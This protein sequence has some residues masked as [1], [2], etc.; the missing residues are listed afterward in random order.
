MSSSRNLKDPT[1]FEN[2]LKRRRVENFASVAVKSKVRVTDEKIVELKTTRD[3]TGRLVYLACT[4]NIELKIVFQF[5]LNPIPLSLASIYGTLKKTPKY[6]LSKHLEQSIKH[7][8][9]TTIDVVIYD[10]MFIVQSLP[11]DLPL[12]FGSIAELS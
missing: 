1:R 3:L 4:R 10:G 9:P 6:K 5:P 7:R 8:E 12:H 11:S 2:P